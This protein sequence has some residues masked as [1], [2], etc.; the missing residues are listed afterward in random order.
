M[1]EPDVVPT[2]LL[3]SLGIALGF[4]EGV[5]RRGGLPAVRGSLNVCLNGFLA[6]VSGHSR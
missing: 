2:S 1:L 4:K 3:C 6:L 5:A